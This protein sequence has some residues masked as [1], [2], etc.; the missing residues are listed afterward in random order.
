MPNYR[1]DAIDTH[2]HESAIVERAI[3]SAAGN[4]LYGELD[5]S[6]IISACAKKVMSMVADTWPCA[7]TVKLYLIN[8]EH[9]K[10]EDVMPATVYRGGS[11]EPISADDFKRHALYHCLLCDTRMRTMNRFSAYVEMCDAVAAAAAQEFCSRMP[12]SGERSQ[13]MYTWTSNRVY[14][15][16]MAILADALRP[17]ADAHI[18]SRGA[19]VKSRLTTS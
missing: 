16:C 3:R 14:A 4:S 5:C 6:G 17:A 7:D 15:E 18:R 10:V 1:F 8:S 12:L 19:T 2:G 11:D 9:T 13:F